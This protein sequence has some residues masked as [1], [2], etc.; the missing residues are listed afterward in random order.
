MPVC[1]NIDDPAHYM[2][3]A[4]LNM[5]KA[6]KLMEETVPKDYRPIE[7]VAYSNGKNVVII[8]T[9]HEYET[10]EENYAHHNCDQMGCGWSHVLYRAPADCF[11]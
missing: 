10:D 11:E 4:E 3:H 5:Q 9:P 1:K 6:E 2:H 8:G 7:V